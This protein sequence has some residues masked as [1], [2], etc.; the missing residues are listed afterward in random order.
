LEELK[1]K[2]IKVDLPKI[3]YNFIRNI[4]L[5][6]FDEISKRVFKEYPL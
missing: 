6:S 3:D 5:K 4:Y 2:N 1:K